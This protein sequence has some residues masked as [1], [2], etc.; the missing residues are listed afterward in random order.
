MTDAG[1]FEDDTASARFTVTG[2][3]YGPRRVDDRVERDGH[4]ITFHGWAYSLEE[5]ARAL[6]EGGFVIDLLREPRPSDKAVAQRPGLAQWQR[7][8]LFMFLRATKRTV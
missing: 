1:R 2:P 4:E 5:Y 7:L 8:P 6:G 3:Y